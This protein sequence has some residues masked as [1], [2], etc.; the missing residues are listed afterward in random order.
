MSQKII[1]DNNSYKYAGRGQFYGI[2]EDS[3][4]HI[5]YDLSIENLEE[6]KEKA[7]VCDS[8]KDVVMLLKVRND[9]VFRNRSIGKK[10]KGINGKYYA[11]RILKQQ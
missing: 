8:V 3:L 4:K 11:V 6:R 7:I 2:L 10:I 1:N 5:V 9:V